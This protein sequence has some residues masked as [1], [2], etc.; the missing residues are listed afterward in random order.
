MK[1][2][3]FFWILFLTVN[4]GLSQKKFKIYGIIND[5][6]EDNLTISLS[7]VDSSGVSQSI[8]PTNGRFYWH[9]KLN[10]TY[11]H[12][13]L[14]LRSSDKYLGSWSFFIKAGI[15]KVTLTKS[16]GQFF[17]ASY[18]NVLFSSEKS[19][20][21]SILTYFEK[22]RMELVNYL[23]TANLNKA[24]KEDSLKKTSNQIKSEALL[25]KVNFVNSDI[26]NY[27]N[28]YF[29]KKEIVDNF[30][31]SVKITPDSLQKIFFLFPEK[32]RNS[33]IG[34]AAINEI[35]RRVL[36]TIG[37]HLPNFIFYDT[38]F[39][40]YNVSNILT[41]KKVLLCFWDAGCKPCISSF[42]MLK[43]VYANYKDSLE[44][45]SISLDAD[46]QKWKTALKKYNL[47]WLNTCNIRKYIGQD[48]SSLY[49][50]QY[51]PQYFL[52]DGSGQLLYHNVQSGDTDDY[53]GLKKLIKEIFASKN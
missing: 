17:L 9:G 23:N 24:D 36:L 6:A 11:E 20:A 32:L 26:N 49:N 7:L 50:V 47:P 39:Y 46:E 37:K 15:T 44:I 48:L 1:S 31:S 12:I 19:R 13:L 18:K 51:I 53:D 33:K 10:Q 16:A 38:S 21:D 2:K 5:Y 34:M 40:K 28:L 35:N 25:A 3:I 30:F 45:I 29:F 27:Y 14:V 22:K 41:T 52:V 43:N 4:V 42:P 8:K